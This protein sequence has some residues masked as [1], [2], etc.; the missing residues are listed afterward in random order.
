[1]LKWSPNNLGVAG[2][3]PEE[4][5]SI[6]LDGT[7]LEENTEFH[8]DFA[9]KKAAEEKERIAILRSELGKEISANLTVEKEAE[10]SAYQQ[11]QSELYDDFA[12]QMK[13][14]VADN[15]S[16]LAS[17]AVELAIAMAGQVIRSE[18]EVDK[19]TILRAIQPLLFKAETGAKLVVTA[20]PDDAEYLESQ[21]QFCEKM[22]IVKIVSDPRCERGGCTVKADTE[23]WDLTIESKLTVLADTVRQTMQSSRSVPEV[24]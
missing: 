17:G 20:N 3:K 21:T 15:I 7:N 5:S 16:S 1:M 19:D 22:N 9:E 13:K 12:D 8:I 23:E 14:I 2:E 6:V 4:L 24:K 18:I 10:I 11:N